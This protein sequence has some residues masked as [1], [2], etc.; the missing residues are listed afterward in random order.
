VSP[1]GFLVVAALTLASA[2]TVV[3]HRNPVHSALALVATMCLLAVLFLG[4]DA[5]LIGFLQVIVYAGAI[6]VLFLF[7]IML[8]NLEREP[9]GLATPVLVGAAA[10]GA[11]G[12]AVLIVRG[13][14]RGTPPATAAV[15]ARF[16]GVA[17]VAERLFTAYLLSFELTSLLLLVAVVGAVA[18]A[19]R[20]PS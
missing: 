2:L 9:R 1:L 14:A 7:V 19:K 16:G 8:L 18:I 13:L 17:A 3:L 12:L 4:L 6:V 11:A 15:E 20:R 5:E 10:A